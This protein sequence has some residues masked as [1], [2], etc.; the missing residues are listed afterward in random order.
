MYVIE[1]DFVVSHFSSDFC[2]STCCSNISYHDLAQ[3]LRKDNF[4]F[5]RSNFGGVLSWSSS[6]GTEVDQGWRE[7]HLLCWF[8]HIWCKA[9]LPF[10]PS[11]FLSPCFPLPHFGLKASTDQSTR[12]FC[13]FTFSHTCTSFP[14]VWVSSVVIQ[15]NPDNPCW[16]GFALQKKKKTTKQGQTDVW[17]LGDSIFSISQGLYDFSDLFCCISLFAFPF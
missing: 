15:V 4:L 1:I 17:E 7:M 10:S 3:Y 11:P 5:L 14:G 13:C 2:D 8:M 6:S 12:P 9:P 16:F